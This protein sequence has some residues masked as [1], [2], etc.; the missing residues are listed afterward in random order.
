[1]KHAMDVFQHH[2]ARGETVAWILHRS[3]F[4]FMVIRNESAA[5]SPPVPMRNQLAQ[6]SS[7][8]NSSTRS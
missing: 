8:R 3:K 7:D 4:R 2:A 6:V 5:R 1:M